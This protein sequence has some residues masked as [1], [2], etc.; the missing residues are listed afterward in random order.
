MITQKDVESIVNENIK[1]VKGVIA[2]TILMPDDIIKIMTSSIYE[3]IS[4]YHESV[5]LR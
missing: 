2:G 5:K 4:K 1:K 3:S